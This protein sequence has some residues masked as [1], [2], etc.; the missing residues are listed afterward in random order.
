MLDRQRHLTIGAAGN[1]GPPRLRGSGLRAIP[2]RVLSIPPLGGLILARFSAESSCAAALNVGAH[3]YCS[4]RVLVNGVEAEPSEGDLF[5]W[6]S[7]PNDGSNFTS[8]S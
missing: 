2:R 3:G 7:V 1:D 8:S 4:V 5:A 6:G